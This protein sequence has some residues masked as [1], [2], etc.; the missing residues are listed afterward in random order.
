MNHIL[1]FEFINYLYN[2]NIIIYHEILFLELKYKYLDIIIFI[3][4]VFEIL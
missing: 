4:L 3:N 2:K 1:F